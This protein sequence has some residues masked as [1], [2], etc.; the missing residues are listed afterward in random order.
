MNYRVSCIIFLTILTFSCRMS[1]QQDDL[2]H[3]N[4]LIHENSPYL[5]Q[6]A[7]NPVNWYPWGE[8]A[9]EKAKKEQKIILVS[10]G[11]AA[12]HWCHVMEHE[13]FEDSA[14]AKVMNDHFVCI[15]VDREERPDIDDVYMTACQLAS[16]RGC[17]WPLNA[18]AL[19]DGRPVWA[20]TYFPKDQWLKVLDQFKNMWVDDKEK[21]EKFA[22]QITAGI[23]QQDEIV[24]GEPQSLNEHEAAQM[25]DAMLRQVDMKKGGRKGAP[26][27]PMPGNYEY[28]LSYHKMSGDANA[29]EAVKV[30]LDQMAY[31][32]IYDQLAGGFARYSTDSIWLAPHFE[33]M[34]YDN[35]QLL[36]LYAHGYQ[37]TQSSLYKDVISNTIQWLNAE[38]TDQSGGFYSS[39]DADSEGEEG[40]FYVWSE[41][42]I[43]EVLGEKSAIFKKYYNVLP[44]GN[45]EDQNILHRQKDDNEVASELGI[46][47]EELKSTIKALKEKL[48]L[49]RNRRIRPGLDDKILTAWNALAIS[50]LVNAAQ[51]LDEDEYL[52]L[53]IRTARFIKEQ[54]WKEDGRLLRNYKD[55]QVK[56]NAFLDDYAFLSE[57]FLNLYQ[58]TFDE[59]WLYDAK[60]L[61]EY[62]INHFYDHEAKLFNY[63]SDIDPPLVARKKEIGD[64][65]IPGSNSAMARNLHILGQYFP[66]TQFQ[67][68][69]DTMLYT[70][71]GPILE[72]G[73]TGFYSNWALLYLEKLIPTYEIAVLGSNAKEVSKKLQSEFLPNVIYLGGSSEGTLELLE[74]KLQPDKTMIYVCQNKVCQL[75][76]TE[77]EKALTQIKYF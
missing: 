68:K 62:A 77:P 34:L 11:Y 55:G 76:V 33:K 9:L 26:K 46:S 73:Q 69:S 61:T 64:N 52:N 1:S 66:E 44:Q 35:A 48:L 60:K 56:I 5:L 17:G 27:F 37:V 71:T 42:E 25:A 6:H 21:L 58:A 22:E 23:Q 49:A 12:C 40:K 57:A 20:G 43:D 75:P 7:H 30:T 47:E 8:E 18:F 19:P 31:G 74:D 70:M 63:T 3:T 54:M 36:S 65:V 38:M 16:G 32:G 67:A 45:W 29:L 50:G 2:T 4:H 53:A 14:V 24:V 15:K 59:T 13:S 28:L 41:A 51:A 10:I 39:L 72:S